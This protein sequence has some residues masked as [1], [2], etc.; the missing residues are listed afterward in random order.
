MAYNL[1]LALSIPNY[2]ALDYE[3][4]SI[5][6]DLCTSYPICTSI[7]ESEPYPLENGAVI[8]FVEL[9]L[10]YTIFDEMSCFSHLM[11]LYICFC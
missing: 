10:L 9:V 8:F 11:W 5:L 6:I 3:S 4:E 2:I 7:Y 1:Y